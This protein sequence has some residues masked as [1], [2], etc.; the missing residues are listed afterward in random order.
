MKKTTNKENFQK[1]LTFIPEEETELVEFVTK[2]I[3]TLDKRAE[4]RRTANAEKNTENKELA[5]KVFDSM[6]E[7]KTYTATDLANMNG[8]T[9]SKVSNLLKM[10]DELGEV[11]REVIKRRP[12]FSI[13]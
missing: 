11:K 3:E 9:T 7:G 2:Q 13:N 12:Y 6:E 1:L 8:L 5:Y 10:L 4:A